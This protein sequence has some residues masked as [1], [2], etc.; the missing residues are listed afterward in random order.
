V[1]PKKKTRTEAQEAFLQWCDDHPEITRSKTGEVFGID[2]RT[3]HRYLSCSTQPHGGVVRLLEVFDL[4][5]AVELEM[6]KRH[7]A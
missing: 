4:Y 7:G 2:L 3:V 6:I 1:K 5:P